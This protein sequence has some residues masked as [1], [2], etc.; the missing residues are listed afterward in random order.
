M[1]EQLYTALSS[2]KEL[3]SSVGQIFESLGGGVRAE[4]GVEGRDA[5]YL[6]E[7]QDLLNAVTMN[8]R[9]GFS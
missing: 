7:L 5:K 4:H 8:L 3:R 2:I 1:T 6:L 9:L